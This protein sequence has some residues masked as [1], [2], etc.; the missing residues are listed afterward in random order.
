MASTIAFGKLS[1]YLS[2]CFVLSQNSHFLHSIPLLLIIPS[3][4]TFSN[5]LPSLKFKILEIIMTPCALHLIT[6]TYSNQG[7]YGLIFFSRAVEYLLAVPIEFSGS[8]GYLATSEIKRL[9]LPLFLYKTIPPL[10]SSCHCYP[11]ALQYLYFIPVLQD[12]E[13]NAL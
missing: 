9:I 3:S 12:P 5:S 2:I 6:I 4:T 13:L 8:I 11:N 1:H 7:I 10:F